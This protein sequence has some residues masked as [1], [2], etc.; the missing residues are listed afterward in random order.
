MDSQLSLKRI[1][2]AISDLAILVA[3]NNQTMTAYEVNKYLTK[4]VGEDASP[5]TVYSAIAAMERKA[6]IRC[7]RNKRG[8]AY[9]L[10]DEG[11]KIIGDMDNIVQEINRFVSKLL[12]IDFV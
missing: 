2:I 3:L 1:F 6:W 9:C 10:T 8:R 12:K 7:V 4:R 11:K 5:S